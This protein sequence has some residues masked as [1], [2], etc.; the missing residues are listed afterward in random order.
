VKVT[1]KSSELEIPKSEALRLQELLDALQIVNESIQLIRAG[2]HRYLMVLSTQLRKLLCETDKR[3]DPLLF[4]IASKT[5]HHLSLYCS[6]TLAE[7]HDENG[8]P[9]EAI[10]EISGFPITATRVRADQSQISLRKIIERKIIRV[11]DETYTPVQV[12]KW[13]ADK[14][15]VHADKTLP[16]DFDFLLRVAPLADFLIQLGS[17]TV[18][19]GADLLKSEIDLNFRCIIA[20]L[21]YAAKAP[22]PFFL[23]DS[24]Q[25]SNGMR[26]A[27]TVD[28]DLTP[29]VL[30]TSIQGRS[31]TLKCDRIIDWSEPRSVRLELKLT[32][33]LF[34]EIE[35]EIDGDVVA[36]LRV[37]DI[38]F[39][40]A[41][42][43]HFV[44]CWNKSVE[45]QAQQFSFELAG[46]T[47]DQGLNRIQQA[48]RTLDY[49]EKISPEKIVLVRFEELAFGTS[50]KG[51]LDMEITGVAKK[52]TNEN[53]ATIPSD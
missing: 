26:L 41:N 10:V 12:I 37:E 32:Y 30:L 50:P 14:V 16:T 44:S 27:I 39:I 31:Y 24:T 36:S 11:R 47:I 45:G 35:L 15:G 21:E 48:L 8:L 29:S 22:L 17:A 9:R 2:K 53:D 38:V 7:T 52:I 34:T 3:A 28:R 6:P 46:H 43:V 4:H 49:E 23:Y 18:F 33:K 42:P 40:Q 51:S 13:Y 19:A 5:D 20:N 1:K 25:A